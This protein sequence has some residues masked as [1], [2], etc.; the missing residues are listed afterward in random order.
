MDTVYMFPTKTLIV[1]P[2]FGAQLR[3]DPS[4]TQSALG[5]GQAQVATS[6]LCS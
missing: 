3:S 5:C 6:S 2:S 4:Y 1:T